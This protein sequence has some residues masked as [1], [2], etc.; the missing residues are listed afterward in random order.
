VISLLPFLT[1]VLT[2]ITS[3]KFKAMGQEETKFLFQLAPVN[4]TVTDVMKI[5]KVVIAAT[6][7]Q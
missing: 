2:N 6:P 4:I 1:D 3:Q 7:S 5:G